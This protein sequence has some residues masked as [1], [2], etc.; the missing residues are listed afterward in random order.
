VIAEI[1]SSR[2]VVYQSKPDN[3]LDVLQV[4]DISAAA[5]RNHKLRLSSFAKEAPYT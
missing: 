2:F 3:I 5:F 1:E 4:K